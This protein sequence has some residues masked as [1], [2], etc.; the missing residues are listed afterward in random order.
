[1]ETNKNLQ[2]SHFQIFNHSI[3]LIGP[4]GDFTKEEIELPFKII[5][6]RLV[7]EKQD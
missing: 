6:S 3:I 5:L 7:L 4:E 1:M 2:S